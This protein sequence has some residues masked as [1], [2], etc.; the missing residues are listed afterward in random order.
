LSQ[1]E[2]DEITT[3]LSQIDQNKK[4]EFEE[5]LQQDLVILANLKKILPD[6]HKR[7]LPILEKL[8]LNLYD[9][10]VLSFDERKELF[11]LFLNS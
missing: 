3:K 1:Q 4:Q 5:R 2:L 10:N 6:Q 7:V 11:K 8:I 9:N